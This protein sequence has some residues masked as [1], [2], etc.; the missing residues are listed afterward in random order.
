LRAAE[1]IPPMKDGRNFLTE[2]PASSEF[3]SEARRA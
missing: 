1:R 3:L 2:R